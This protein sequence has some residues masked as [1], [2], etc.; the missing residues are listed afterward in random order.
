MRCPYPS[1]EL[2]QNV[3]LAILSLVKQLKE[4][5]ITEAN[6]IQPLTCLMVNFAAASSLIKAKINTNTNNVRIED[7]WE[8]VHG[9]MPVSNHWS[10]A[11]QDNS[12]IQISEDIFRQLK[13]SVRSLFQESCFWDVFSVVSEIALNRTSFDSELMS[14]SSLGRFTTPFS[15][16]D[17]ILQNSLKKNLDHGSI[18]EI[19]QICVL[20]PAVGS[21]I[22]IG[23]AYDM[24]SAYY[25]RNKR[26]LDERGYDGIS[27]AELIV[28]KN[29]YAVDISEGSLEN[30]SFGIRLRSAHL[31]NE[32]P[33]VI[34]NFR[35]GNALLDVPF[36]LEV[37]TESF[38][39]LSS[40]FAKGLSIDSKLT[41]KRNLQFP[42]LFYFPQENEARFKPFN[43]RKKFPEVFLEKEP[44]GF[45][46]I[47]GNPPY[48]NIERLTREEFKFFTSKSPVTY[49]TARRRFDLYVLF[50]EKIVRDL[51]RSDGTLGLVLSDKFLT[52]S[53]S[54][55]IR[56]LILSKVRIKEIL[57]LRKWKTFPGVSARTIVLLAQVKDPDNSNFRVKVGETNP[58]ST[59]SIEGRVFL[60]NQE[61]FKKIPNY[62]FRLRW[63]DFKEAL[64]AHIHSRSIP[65]GEICYV[66]WGAQPG[67]SKR[68][69]FQK[70]NEKCKNVKQSCPWDHEK[71]PNT[72]CKRLI[73]GR[74]VDSYQ[75]VYRD[76]FLL[77][78]PILLNRPAFPQLFENEKIV[79][80]EV[81]GKRGLIAALDTDNYYTDHSLS[82]IVLK[83]DL[84]GM[85][86]QAARR[87]GIRFDLDASRPQKK[88]YY[89]QE[90]VHFDEKET[91]ASYTRGA[92]VYRDDLNP[93]FG[94]GVLLA[95][96]NSSLL[97]FYFEEYL[98]GGLNVFPGHIKQLPIPTNLVS[99]G[100]HP[101]LLRVVEQAARL[102][103]SNTCLNESFRAQLFRAIDRLVYAMYDISEEWIEQ[104]E[105]EKKEKPK[106]NFSALSK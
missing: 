15:L 69:I 75:I 88:N 71:C 89:H 101:A 27:P 73:K 54:R 68:V 14:K 82:C 16:A 102:L 23:I 48:V 87:R 29:L 32:I 38:C 77:Y 61:A 67:L 18:D 76:R 28:N 40:K 96:L 6:S 26:A 62:M 12:M 8:S 24:L 17:Y 72:L 65:L 104:I 49:K 105:K 4:K 25:K 94:L 43:W 39:R 34:P 90:F 63:D 97:K 57:D 56:R 42:E 83:S 53:Y 80:R 60:I 58:L 46:L 36:D 66:S 22:F 45:D 47:V 30:L 106:Y 99:S 13:R 20:D 10:K 81:S 52:E 86:S 74:D 103:Q 93:S 100:F 3:E 70:S 98:S 92:T 79:V 84:I 50:L 33:R 5:S 19:L 41:D 44:S 9:L 64:I 51:L 91:I 85:G 31:N 78:D 11:I 2:R 55:E 1:K 37:S 35:A 7:V 95:I 21:G 59:G